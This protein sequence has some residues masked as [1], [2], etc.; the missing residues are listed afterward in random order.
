MHEELVTT[1]IEPST[2]ILDLPQQQP[3]S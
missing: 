2:L 1:R 3:H